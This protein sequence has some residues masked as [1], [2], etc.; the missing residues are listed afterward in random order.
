MQQKVQFVSTIIHQP[1]LI[2]LDEP[3]SGL[4][5]INSKLIKQE[6]RKL[7]E[8]GTS[9]IFSTHRMEQ[10]EEI[11][12]HI[13]LINKGQNILEGDVN[14]IKEEYKDHLFKFTYQGELDLDL[15]LAPIIE[16]QAQTLTI[17][18]KELGEANHFI[19][20]LMDKGV[21]IQRFEEVLPTLND[22]FIKKVTEAA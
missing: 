20:M 21:L 5:P 9:I 12:E 15:I 2:I 18:F 14:Q 3:F 8:E 13:V 17:K 22:I 4:D 16:H 10:V 1:P 19:R 7:N 6:I 11:C